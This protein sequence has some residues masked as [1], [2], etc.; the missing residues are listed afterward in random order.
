MKISSLILLCL[1]LSVLVTGCSSRFPPIRR[2]W[3]RE[4]DF[5]QKRPVLYNSFVEEGGL[6]SNDEAPGEKRLQNKIKK[7]L[8]YEQ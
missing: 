7:E 8:V 4:S 2:T 5:K 3:Q 6:D 1:V